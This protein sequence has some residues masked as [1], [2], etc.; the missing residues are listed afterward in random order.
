ML[1]P[2]SSTTKKDPQGNEHLLMHFNVEGPRNKGVANM[3]LVKRAGRGEYE[4]RHFYV[5]V[6]GQQRI[7]PGECGCI[8]QGGGQQA[9]E[10]DSVWHKVGLRTA[11]KRRKHNAATEDGASSRMSVGRRRAASRQMEY[12]ARHDMGRALGS[13]EAASAD[14]VQGFRRMWACQRRNPGLYP[15]ICSSTVQDQISI[16]NRECD[17]APVL[18]FPVLVR[19]TQVLSQP[20]RS[21]GGNSPG[22]PLVKS[23]S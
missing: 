10:N 6:R 9:E 15:A 8:C 17:I 13:V 21:G 20:V 16:D 23:P 1:I 14:R 18:D 19:D 7:Y 11:T 3:H 4:Y 12:A 22:A 5:D 2:R